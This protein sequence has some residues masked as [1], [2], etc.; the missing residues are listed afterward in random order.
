[1]VA[2]NKGESFEKEWYVHM[3]GPVTLSEDGGEEAK[4]GGGEDVNEDGE[5]GEK[6]EG[7]QAEVVKAVGE[8][9]AKF[10]EDVAELVNER[11]GGQ[12]MTDE[13]AKAVY[14][15]AVDEDI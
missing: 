11:F 2:Q 6:D 13:E 4:A 12:G 7:L 15:R 3:K 14:E 10:W 5:H 8:V 9:R 1:L